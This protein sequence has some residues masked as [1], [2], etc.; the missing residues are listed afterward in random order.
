MASRNE[1]SEQVSARRVKAVKIAHT[2]RL[3]GR[4]AK[5]YEEL[6]PF[7]ETI[8]IIFPVCR[9]NVHRIQK[10]AKFASAH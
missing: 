4:N 1:N 9:I 6:P 3:N 8:A 2:T 5:L 10:S 7:P